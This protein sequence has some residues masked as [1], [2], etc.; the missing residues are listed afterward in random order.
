ME[1]VLSISF[2]IFKLQLLLLIT[3]YSVI[4]LYTNNP[5]RKLGIS[6]TTGVKC[7]RNIYFEVILYY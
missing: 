3:V 5:P 2:L 6:L 4:G 7:L 1:N